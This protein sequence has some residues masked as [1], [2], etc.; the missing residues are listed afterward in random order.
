MANLKKSL[1][2]GMAA[3][4]AVCL[5]LTSFNG[6][7][8]A[9]ETPGGVGPD[10]D[11]PAKFVLKYD[12]NEFIEAAQ[13]AIASGE[14]YAADEMEFAKSDYNKLF[15]DSDST[16]FEFYP[17]E[18]VDEDEEEVSSPEE[19]IAA[20]SDVLGADVRMFIRV[21]GWDAE[22][23]EEY[24]MTGEE[25]IIFL[26]IN[27]LEEKLTF[28]IDINGFITKEI[29]V[30]GNTSSLG[31]FGSATGSNADTK[32]PGN[33][34][35]TNVPGKNDG[36]AVPTVP[37]TTPAEQPTTETAETT[38]AETTPAETTEAVTDPTETLPVESSEAE[39]VEG[40]TAA[41]DVTAPSESVE[42]TEAS[43]EAEVENS[44]AASE[45]ATTEA[46][47]DTEE[48]TTE[49][50]SEEATEA[51]TE[52]PATVEEATD[53]E[54]EAPAAEEPATEAEPVITMSRNDVPVVGSAPE[55]ADDEDVEEEPAEEPAEKITGDLTGKTLGASQIVE[56]EVTSKAFVTSAKQIMGLMKAASGEYTLNI[57]YSL[58][59]KEKTIYNTDGSSTF[60][61]EEKEQPIIITEFVNGTFNY[62]DYL[63]QFNGLKRSSTQETVVK[64]SAFKNYNLTV[65]VEYQL[66][67]ISING[68]NKTAYI[69]PWE[70]DKRLEELKSNPT[71][72]T[73]IPE[74]PE[75]VSHD[76]RY[77]TYINADMRSKYFSK[78]THDP[79]D[80]PLIQPN[81][82]KNC[83]R[84]EWG[85][86][87]GP[88]N[89]HY[90]ILKYSIEKDIMTY[91]RC[92][93]Y[94]GEEQ[95]EKHYRVNFITEENDELAEI[96][97]EN[98]KNIE[99]MNQ[100]REDKHL[101]LFVIPD[102][103]MD[104]KIAYWYDADTKEEYE[105]EKI[106]KE[107]ITSPRTFVAVFKEV[108]M[109]T[110]TFKSGNH[111][112]FS[113][114]ENTVVFSDIVSGTKWEDA[115]IEEPTVTE[116]SDSGYRFTS[117]EPK[118]P[119]QDF[120]ITEDLT[121]VAQYEEMHDRQLVLKK[122]VT[123]S[124]DTTGMEFEFEVA[125]MTN[126]EIKTDKTNVSLTDEQG[127]KT[128][129]FKL[130]ANEEIT[131]SE[132]T[133]STTF[134]IK[135]KPFTHAFYSS[136]CS[137]IKVT[138]RAGYEISVPDATI[139]GNLEAAE[140][141][142]TFINAMMMDADVSVSKIISGDLKPE[143]GKEETYEFRVEIWKPKFEVAAG[144][145]WEVFKDYT[146]P[147][148]NES[149]GTFT[150]TGKGSAA[151]NF[152][153]YVGS[154]H[155]FRI[156]E[157][158]KGEASSAV[159]SNNEGQ[160]SFAS[161]RFTIS[162]E[163]LALNCE[164]QYTKQSLTLEK[165]ILDDKEIPEGTAFEFNVIL[166]DENGMG[167]PEIS[168]ETE[169]TVYFNDT[170]LET[171]GTI[172]AVDGKYAI[173][174]VSKSNE[175][176]KITFTDIPPATKYQIT[177]LTYAENGMYESNLEE[178]YVNGLRYDKNSDVVSS[179]TISGVFGGI[180]NVNTEYKLPLYRVSKN[181][182][183]LLQVEKIDPDGK[184]KAILTAPNNGL[185]SELIKK[186]L[187]VEGA[188][189]WNSYGTEGYQEYADDLNSYAYIYFYHGQGYNSNEYLRRVI[190]DDVWNDFVNGDVEQSLLDFQIKFS[191]V[192]TRKYEDILPP[193]YEN[194]A[195]LIYSVECSYLTSG[196]QNV[197]FV[198][199][200]KQSKSS[201][202]QIEKK[203]VEPATEDSTFIFKVENVEEGS[204]GKGEIFYVPVT[205]KKGTS[206]NE[207]EVITGLYMGTY[208]I[209]EEE[210]MRYK[211]TDAS[212]KTQEIEV[213]E[214]TSTVVFEN[215]KMSDG[216]FSDSSM[217]V[218]EVK[219]NADGNWE[220]VPDM[221]ENK[222]QDDLPKAANNIVA[223]IPNNKTDNFAEHGFDDGD[224][225]LARC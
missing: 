82:D 53:A 26:F 19:D 123:G 122:E 203:L 113:N 168:Y 85:S 148:K 129:N 7:A 37:E 191:G 218:N 116:K 73:I 80:C 25:E 58:K 147:N 68:E 35:D 109:H 92:D 153:N 44:T 120:A 60:N 182:K 100:Q 88:V 139:S 115:D 154:Y 76:G 11:V 50:Q 97:V 51:A 63:K 42:S 126:D 155:E 181:L 215:K 49:A 160:Q 220:F 28:Q 209:T 57:V 201:I 130:A 16:V 166:K 205:V 152:G 91:V 179:R 93:K 59:V 17:E 67:Q 207:S 134:T 211:V 29:T 138:D 119:S 34:V 3:L 127:V 84:T 46:V 9:S 144:G 195:H 103:Y 118:L 125:F 223:L 22:A 66:D 99:Y 208:H 6:V 216:Y 43:S 132:L 104:Q 194:S 131:F 2:R 112:T 133:K 143:E 140:N 196:E 177:E 146:S 81:K 197:T 135:E 106:Y 32:A 163:S 217:I 193:V 164:N 178:I 78:N 62:G 157:I 64:Q 188:T 171:S 8:W 173:R 33:K 210:H 225:P 36:T 98:N 89:I 31:G 202:L 128:Y 198:N 47:A 206:F 105:T 176:G 83:Q 110:V 74:F 183:Q 167:I 189:I 18:R 222:T 71:I 180:Q 192:Q 172:H 4:L 156:V 101:E 102:S 169:G 162:K 23:E 204:K 14:I 90:V 20:L 48:A 69:K 15:N 212:M 24:V 159:W 185:M 87:Y 174:L 137:D 117:W 200:F 72:S 79:A 13:E 158:G 175:I 199:E 94:G 213:S 61:F 224:V 170:L 114:G 107:I 39:S 54:T 56:E 96:I 161:N 75:I 187:L 70:A 45:E 186:G 95:E 214:H 145:A 142:V 184:Q 150:I 10:E 221:S 121:F 40:T 124:V 12:A 30:P 1:K 86:S 149:K 38:P 151:L 77:P 111:G 141:T 27:A 136:K 219:E 52:E 108:E 55:V 5:V 165:K 41:E 190:R 65:N 21:N